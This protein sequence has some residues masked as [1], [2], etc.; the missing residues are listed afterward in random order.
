MNTF[1]KV[2]KYV[3]LAFAIALAIGIIEFGLGIGYIV[4]QS[5]GLIHSNS[6]NKVSNV[7]FN[8]Y[9]SYLDI[10]LSVAS[11]TIKRGDTLRYETNIDEIESKQENN[12]LVIKDKGNKWFRSNKN[13]SITL[14]VPENLTFEKVIINMGVGELDVDNVSL[15]NADLHLGVGQANIKSDLTGNTKIDC[16]IGE[17]DLNLTGSEEDYT[18]KLDKGIGEINVNNK[19]YGNTTIGNGRNYIDVDGGIGEINIKTR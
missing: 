18:F 1:Q 11:L 12:K 7:N 14:Y 4:L 6:N 2:I 9:S 13:S 19:S 3:A 16:G 8:E 15:N 10:D 5:T 17:V